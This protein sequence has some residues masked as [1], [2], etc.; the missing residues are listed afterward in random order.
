MQHIKHQSIKQKNICYLSVLLWYVVMM[1]NFNQSFKISKLETY[2][3]S[4]LW[5]LYIWSKNLHHRYDSIQQTTCPSNLLLAHEVPTF[6]GQELGSPAPLEMRCAHCLKTSSGEPGHG[7][8]SGMEFVVVVQCGHRWGMASKLKLFSV[9]WHPADS[10]NPRYEHTPK[11]HLV[12]QW[13]F[14]I[15]DLVFL[16]PWNRI[17]WNWLGPLSKFHSRLIPGSHWETEWRLPCKHVVA[18]SGTAF[19]SCLTRFLRQWP[20]HTQDRVVVEHQGFE[21]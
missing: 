6:S 19:R 20:H 1:L 10:R 13:P 15:F 21:S 2:L 17:L 14:Q 11:I 3:A 5:H 12:D 18:H 7:P 8:Q 16:N 9:L 4:C